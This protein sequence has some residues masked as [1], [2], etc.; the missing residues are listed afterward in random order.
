MLHIISFTNDTVRD[1][2]DVIPHVLTN[3]TMKVSTGGITTR[4]LRS[5]GHVFPLLTCPYF[6]VFFRRNRSHVRRISLITTRR[7][8]IV[9]SNS[10]LITFPLRLNE[11]GHRIQ[12]INHS[13]IRAKGRH[14]PLRTIR[15]L[16]G[17]ISSLFLVIGRPVNINLLTLNQRKFRGPVVK[18]KDRHA[19]APCEFVGLHSRHRPDVNVS[20]HFSSNSLH[21]RP[22]LGTLYRLLN[23]NQRFTYHRTRMITNGTTRFLRFSKVVQF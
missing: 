13:P 14:S 6:G 8:K 23:I 3:I 11:N 21:V 2:R 7:R 17:Q 1:V 9:D 16:G 4:N 12:I 22:I 19:R 18:R 5:L 10:S 15:R 20:R